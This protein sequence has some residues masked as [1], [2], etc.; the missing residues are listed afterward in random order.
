MKKSELRKIIKESVKELINEQ[1]N[2]STNINPACMAVVGAVWDPTTNTSTVPPVVSQAFI[3]AMTNKPC[4]FYYSR[5]QTLADKRGNLISTNSQGQINPLC[6]VG[7]NP[8]WQAKLTHKLNYIM[9]LINNN[10]CTPPP[11]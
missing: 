6:A 4:N 3:N 7:D 11:K 10:G 2:P 5:H 8:A 9:N 1:Y